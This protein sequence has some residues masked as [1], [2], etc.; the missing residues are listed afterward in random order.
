[1]TSWL[2]PLHYYL[3]MWDAAWVVFSVALTS[4]LLMNVYWG[5]LITRVLANAFG[6][7]R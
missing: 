2:G 7:K 1:M 4:I 3:T 6:G 5:L